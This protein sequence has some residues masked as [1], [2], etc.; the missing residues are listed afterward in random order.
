M[1]SLTAFEQQWG[2][3]MS[4]RMAARAQR[5]LAAKAAGTPAADGTAR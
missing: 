5:W 2:G 4:E 1:A 3:T